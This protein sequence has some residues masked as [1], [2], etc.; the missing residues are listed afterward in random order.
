MVYDFGDEL[1][2]YVPKQDIALIEG[3]EI[4]LVEKVLS[5][6]HIIFN[7]PNAVNACGCGESFAVKD[8]QDNND[9]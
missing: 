3:T 5:Q 1:V 2:V 8:A 4:A 6:K 7:N 9:T